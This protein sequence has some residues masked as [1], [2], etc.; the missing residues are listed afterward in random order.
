[1]ALRYRCP[2]C[3]A[4]LNPGTKVI[5]R[6]SR[7]RKSALILLSPQVGNYTVILPEDFP[8]KEGEK[9]TFFCPVCGAELTSP[10]NAHFNEVLRERADGGFDHVEFHRV[11]GRHATF[12][13]TGD[14]VRAFGDDAGSFEPVNFF[15]AGRADA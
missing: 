4:V 14:E 12:V 13:V 2:H 1:M 5:L 6:V 15:G 3:K 7:G 10:V 8:L 11:Y 9:A